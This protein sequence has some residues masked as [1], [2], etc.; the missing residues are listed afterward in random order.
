MSDVTSDICNDVLVASGAHAQAAQRSARRGHRAHRSCRR[1]TAVTCGSYVHGY[2]SF[3][4]GARSPLP[5]HH[6]RPSLSSIKYEYY[7]TRLAFRARAVTRGGLGRGA[8]RRYPRVA[9]ASGKASS[10]GGDRGHGRSQAVPPPLEAQTSGSYELGEC[11]SG[12]AGGG[13]AR[14][15]I[16]KTPLKPFRKR[17]TTRQ[18]LARRGTAADCLRPSHVMA[19]PVTDFLH[20]R[21]ACLMF[22]PG[23]HTSRRDVNKTPVSCYCHVINAFILDV[24]SKA[25]LIAIISF[26]IGIVFVAIAV[27][28][29]SLS[30]LSLL[31]ILS[32][33]LS[34]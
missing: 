25:E 29:F 26:A 31:S 1:L 22:M 15:Q 30:L 7:Y 24:A 18:E 8:S 32:L 28:S 10:S 17:T 16:P 4:A 3:R 21:C 23:S 12:E 2:A 14:R 33:S 27:T 19:A 13:E 9:G 6:M 34:G 5:P 11:G 20:K